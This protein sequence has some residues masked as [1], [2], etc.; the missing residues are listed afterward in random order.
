[1]K[2]VVVVTIAVRAD[3]TLK[4][5]AS[6]PVDF[7]QE[8][9]LAATGIPVMPDG[10]GLA[11]CHLK[12]GDI[13]GIGKRMLAAGTGLTVVPVAAGIGAPVIDLGNRVAKVPLCGRLQH[14]LFKYGKGRS[15][16]AA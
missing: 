4:Q 6:T 7:A 16:L 15:Q 9:F 5:V 11:V 12:S 13:D 3:D 2:M 10:Y 8:G 1:M 14:F